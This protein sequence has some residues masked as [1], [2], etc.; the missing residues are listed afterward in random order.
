[1]WIVYFVS[2]RS[3]M[4]LSA[5]TAT[6][7]RNTTWIVASR[8][9]HMMLHTTCWRRWVL[10]KESNLWNTYFHTYCVLVLH[11]DLLIG[12][13]GPY[14]SAD[15]NPRAWNILSRFPA[16][17]LPHSQPGACS[18]P[19]LTSTVCDLYVQS[20]VLNYCILVEIIFFR[21]GL[22]RFQCFWMHVL[23]SLLLYSRWRTRATGCPRWGTLRSIARDCKWD[24]RSSRPNRKWSSLGVLWKMMQTVQG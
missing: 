22:Y 3:Q 10:S 14:P 8:F 11:G 15:E 16:P 21:N 4:Y 23:M 20:C 17:M 9:S 5:F 1:M 19:M 13:E 7:Q 18:L 12:H 6:C 24:T 2:F